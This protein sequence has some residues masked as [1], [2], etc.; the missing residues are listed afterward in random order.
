[1]QFKK[2]LQQNI[3]NIKKV[4]ITIKHLQMNQILALNDPYGF[5]MPLNESNHSVSVG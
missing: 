4:M 3:E 1:M 5:D 2:W